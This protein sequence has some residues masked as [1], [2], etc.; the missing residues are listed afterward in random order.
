MLF[1]LALILLSNQVLQSHSAP[2]HLLSCLREPK[3]CI[4]PKVISNI[5]KA[6]STLYLE[7]IY[8]DILPYFCYVRYPTTIPYGD[9]CIPCSTREHG[10]GILERE[11]RGPEWIQVCDTFCSQRTNNS[12]KTESPVTVEIRSS[13]PSIKPGKKTKSIYH[14]FNTNKLGSLSDYGS[15]NGIT[16]PN[17]TNKHTGILFCVAAG[18][19]SLLVIGI[20]ILCT[21]KNIIIPKIVKQQQ[22]IMNLNVRVIAYNPV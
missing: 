3:L 2:L 13:T 16:D 9:T 14:K 12:V 4:P 11:E 17:T 5:E 19:S 18:I 20:V 22:Q 15:E 8:E 6:R 7:E 10:C 1:E 21:Y